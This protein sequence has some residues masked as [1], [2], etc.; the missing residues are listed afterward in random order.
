MNSKMKGK[1]LGGVQMQ[2]LLSSRHWVTSPSCYGDVFA[3]LEA[4]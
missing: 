2:D 4:L 3:H 1:G